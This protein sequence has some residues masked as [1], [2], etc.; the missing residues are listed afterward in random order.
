MKRRTLLAGAGVSGFALSFPLVAK[1]QGTRTFRIGVLVSG[2]PPHPV[3]EAV[4]VGL[5]AFG[6]VQGRNLALEVRYAE[7]KFEN[8]IELFD[9]VF[10]GTRH[11]CLLV[12]V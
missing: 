7:G 4:R 11:P 1:A 12:S 2:S 5:E 3:V 10:L 9:E 8:A 6:Y